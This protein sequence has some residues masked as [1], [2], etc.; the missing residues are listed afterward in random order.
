[1]LAKQGGSINRKI[2]PSPLKKARTKLKKDFNIRTDYAGIQDIDFIRSVLT[3]SEPMVKQAIFNIATAWLNRNDLTLESTIRTVA[4]YI[5]YSTRTKNMAGDTIFHTDGLF[6]YANTLTIK[7]IVSYIIMAELKV[8]LEDLTEDSI[9]Y[10][11]KKLL[12]L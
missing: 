11:C 5:S 1:M 8:K 12:E 4:S 9:S 2:E 10:Y 3:Y 7:M 6:Q